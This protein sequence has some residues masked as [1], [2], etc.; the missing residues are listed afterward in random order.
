MGMRLRPF[1]RRFRSDVLSWTRFVVVTSVVT[2]LVAGGGYGAYTELWPAIIEHSYFQLRT[3][4]VICDSAAAQPIALAARAGLYDGTSLWQIDV[5]KAR[6]ELA[7]FSWVRDA[8]IRRLFPDKVSV[9][10]YRREPV[11][12]TVGADGPYLID[13]K[14]IVYREEGLVPYADLPYLTG[15]AD[16]PTQA[17]RVERLRMA[18]SLMQAAERRGIQISQVHVEADGAFWLYPDAL[19]VAVRA[20]RE[21][22]AATIADRL[23]AVLAALPTDRVDIRE[24][25]LSYR[26]RA[27]LRAADGRARSLISTFSNKRLDGAWETR[28]RG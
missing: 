8:R 27:V 7:S 4:K 26:D 15:W 28:T 5:H 14:G 1:L 17:E 23:R 13:D 18:M 25:D 10:V 11:A 3:V 16:A 20:G 6:R 22:R 24:I 12:A 2:G 21:P 19:A 9:E